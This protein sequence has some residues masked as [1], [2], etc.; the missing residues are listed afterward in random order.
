MTNDTPA[1]VATGSDPKEPTP[2]TK[3]ATRTT[4]AAAEKATKSARNKTKTSTKTSTKAGTE[5]GTKATQED[6]GEESSSSDTSSSPSADDWGT[7]QS[8]SDHEEDPTFHHSFRTGAAP[9]TPS[10]TKERLELTLRKHSRV[11]GSHRHHYLRPF[12]IRDTD[13]NRT[14]SGCSTGARQVAEVLYSA[15]AFLGLKLNRSNDFLE[16]HP[17]I[18]KAAREH[19][20]ENWLYTC[21]IHEYLLARL[22][23]IEGLKG[24]SQAQALAEIQQA[25]VRPLLGGLHLRGDVS[26]LPPRRYRSQG[27]CGYLPEVAARKQPRSRQVEETQVEE[28][29]H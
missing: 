27:V 9:F 29:Q 10:A 1:D 17:K 28:L 14:L 5:A 7:D 21:G 16:S 25:R 6:P 15:T 13:F 12:V 22:D 20:E 18:D 2:T 3:T 19:L 24:N 11:P 8:S 26:N 4:K 23:I